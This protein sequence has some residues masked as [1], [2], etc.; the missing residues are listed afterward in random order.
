V[1]N[2]PDNSI[3]IFSRQG[4]PQALVAQFASRTMSATVGNDAVVACQR[5][6]SH[7]IEN[8]QLVSKLPN[9]FFVSP[10]QGVC[11]SEIVGP[12]PN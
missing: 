11:V 4:I 6:V 7:Q 3:V 12:L 1:V 10:H 2:D 8:A 5:F 9:L